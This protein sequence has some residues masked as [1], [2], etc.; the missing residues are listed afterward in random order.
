MAYLVGSKGV[1][2]TIE[3]LQPM[4]DQESKR[5][6]FSVSRLNAEMR[7]IIEGSLPLIWV[8][9]ELSN[10]ATPRSGHLYFS[11]KDDHAQV[12]CA[13]FR[14]KR[15]LLRH[16]PA[17]GD[18]VLARARVSFYEPRGEFQL[19]IEHL[20]PAGAGSAQ[21]AFEALKRKLQ[22]EGLFD[23]QRKRPL[24]AF[25]TRVGVITSPSGAAVRDVLQ[26]LRRR[27]PHL[28]VT[29][30]P[31]QVQGQGAV[32]SLLEALR[33]ALDRRDCDVLLLTRG[34][35]SIEDLAAFNDEQLARL[36]AAATIPIVS[37]VGHEIDFSISDFVADRRAPTPS[38]AAELVSPDTGTLLT[39]I[40][41]QHR[42]LL[43]AYRRQLDTRRHR[44]GQ[45]EGRLQRAA[46]ASRLRQQQQQ[47]DRVE[48]RLNRAMATRLLAAQGRLDGAQR[49]LRSQEPRRTLL[50]LRQ[51]QTT[52]DR[53]LRQA[54]RSLFE[55]HTDRVAAAARQLHA[56]SPLAVMQRGYSVLRREDDGAV[57]TSVA[58][59][60]VDDRVRGMLADGSL[61]LRI[62]GVTANDEPGG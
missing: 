62:E 33:T 38:A 32:D 55:R 31:A 10:L 35:G 16:V 61:D 19:I 26:V 28:A 8:E 14:N 49:R 5:D 58:Q 25:P 2:R 42:R 21:R 59:I 20:E 57:V 52:A 23:T 22:A 29:V 41:T 12:R 13:L 11:L 60:G 7:A 24:P 40:E 18:Q 46:P 56:L 3:T 54:W 53:R 48:L 43:A 15:Q 30:Y 6:I 51:R 36:I 44:L 45:L 27:A 4:P 39:Q 17:D 1:H 47:L 50:V 34:G 9:G 37:A